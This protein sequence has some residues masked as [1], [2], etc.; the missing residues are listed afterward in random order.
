MKSYLN[1]YRQEIHQIEHDRKSHCSLSK[2]G[3]IGLCENKTNEWNLSRKT[4]IPVPGVFVR[5]QKGKFVFLGFY[6]RVKTQHY[7]LIVGA[8]E[9]LMAAKIP[10][11]L[12]C[13][14]LVIF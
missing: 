12:W 3:W 14:F 8:E 10:R 4:K 6:G 9:A 7:K 13:R 5:E 2:G 1:Q 11:R